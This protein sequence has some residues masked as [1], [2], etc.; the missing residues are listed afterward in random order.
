MSSRYRAI[1][2]ALSV[3]AGE[4]QNY[5]RRTAGAPNLCVGQGST[6]RWRQAEGLHALFYN[7]KKKPRLLGIQSRLAAHDLEYRE[8]LQLSDDEFRR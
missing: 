4:I 1:S 2:S 7:I 6:N 8:N 3:G 5:R